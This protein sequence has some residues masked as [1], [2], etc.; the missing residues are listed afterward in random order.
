MRKN[1]FILL[2]FLT[3]ALTSFGQKKTIK[4]FTTEDDIRPRNVLY[5]SSGLDGY[6]LST[7]FMSRLNGD[8]DL[9]TPRYTLFLH[10]GSSVHY[11]FG[12][13]FGLYSG[14]SI[15]NIGFIEKFNNSDSTVKRR[16]YTFGIPLGLKFG[17][18][19]KGFYLMA[20]GG[21]DF[22]FNY[23][24]KGFTNRSNKKKFNEWFSQRTPAAMPYVFVGARFRPGAVAKVTYY[25]TNFLN[26]SFKDGVSYP[27]AWYN[28]NL[29]TLSLG[30]DIKYYPKK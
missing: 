28:V 12:N 9:T 25:P 30:F 29:L 13:H 26:T 4:V 24:E 6:L 21:I 1:I 18:F 15:K 27:Y 8:P 22:P 3:L 7:A 5:V 11:D 23:K 17:N 20:G 14:L 2:A 19:D 10:L 16:V